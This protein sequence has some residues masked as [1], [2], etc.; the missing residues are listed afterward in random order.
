M[1]I[2]MDYATADFDRAYPNCR[3]LTQSLLQC[4]LRSKDPAKTPCE[5]I[6]AELR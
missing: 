4:H 5:P 1:S 2:D 6:A 3:H